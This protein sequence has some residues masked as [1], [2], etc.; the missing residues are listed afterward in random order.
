MIVIDHQPRR[1][2]VSVFGEIIKVRSAAAALLNVPVVLSIVAFVGVTTWLIAPCPESV[3]FNVAAPSC[4][5]LSE[6]DV[7]AAH[8]VR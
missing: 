5:A 3:D 2:S 7:T 8:P 6:N 1:V 4:G